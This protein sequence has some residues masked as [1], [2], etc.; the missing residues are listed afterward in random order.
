[1]ASF[2]KVILMGNLT[3]DPEL[4]VTPQ[5]MAICKIGLAVN[6]TFKGS[7]GNNQEEV[8]FVDVDAFGKQAEVI[9]KFM[10]KGKPILIE[11]RLRMDSWTTKE[12]DKRS[13]MVVVVENFQFVGGR[14]DDSGGEGYTPRQGGGAAHEDRRGGSAGN[15]DMKDGAEDVPF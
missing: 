10:N 11:G 3:R 4:R 6:R 7:D 15:Y 13:K 9:G 8:T 2:N 12:G 14:N 1:M 5:G